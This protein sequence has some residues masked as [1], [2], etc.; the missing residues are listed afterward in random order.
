MQKYCDAG[1]QEGLGA[2]QQ[3]GSD[4]GQLESTDAGQ[5]E[6]SDAGQQEGNLRRHLRNITTPWLPL[7]NSE[8]PSRNWWKKEEVTES[9]MP[10]T[11][12][13]IPLTPLALR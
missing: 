10:A 11:G 8:K 3:K 9:V 13:L 4:A 1:Q 12:S 2:P 7:Y 6:V 5:H